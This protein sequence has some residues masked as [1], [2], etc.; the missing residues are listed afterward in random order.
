M[1]SGKDITVERV[2]NGAKDVRFFE[3]IPEDAKVVLEEGE[4]GHVH[5]TLG[6]DE[7]LKQVGVEEPKPK[8]KAKAA[9]TSST[10]QQAA[11]KK[12]K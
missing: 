3:R 10:R 5:I 1:P 7:E 6:T 12:A 11:A 8:A 9:P 2:V 4:D